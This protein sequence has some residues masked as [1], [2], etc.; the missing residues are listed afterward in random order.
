[1]TEILVVGFPKSG[2]TWLS[3][4]LSD[5]L[6]WPVRGIGDARPLAEQGT[7]RGD[8]CLIRQLHLYPEPL[9]DVYPV[10]ASAH[11]L[12][13]NA[14]DGQH[15]IVHII[16]DPRDVAVSIGHY[17]GIKD[18]QRII[19]QVM[20]VGAHPLWGIGWAQ[21]VK[22][23]RKVPIPVVE[24]RYEWLHADPL[25]ELQR[26]IDRLGVRA[27]KPLGEVTERQQIDA[28]RA[29]I[30]A[31][32]EEMAHGITP[33]LTNLRA[34]RVGDWRQE[35]TQEDVVAMCDWFGLE[36][37]QLCYEDNPEWHLQFVQTC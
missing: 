13:V 25:L 17:W 23:W 34:G 35:F 28:R 15:K 27:T 20:A 26:I 33:Q 2:N 19:T 8:G 3:R 37:M 1:M 31:H 24:T 7:M 18:L 4:L 21:Y 5:A 9:G 11:S 6:D 30:R 10:V 32:G 22:A 12:N 29:D 36:L 14:V 16:R